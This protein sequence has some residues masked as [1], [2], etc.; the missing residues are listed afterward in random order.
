MARTPAPEA[1]LPRVLVGIP[2]HR[3]V[4]GPFLQS[5]VTLLEECH[6]L[7]LDLRVAYAPG[8][9]IHLARDNLVR[10]FL[11]GSW[12]Y[13]VMVDTDQ[14]FSPEV[15]RRL[16]RWGKPLVA[17]VIVNRLGDPKPVAYAREGTSLTG[18]AVYAALAEEVWAYLSQ[19]RPERLRAPT[20]TLPLGADG[21]PT[22]ADLP[23][24]VRAGLASPLLAVDAVGGGMTC[25]SRAC[26]ERL[27]PT[28]G[29]RYFGWEHG[30]EDLSFC[31]LVLEAGYAG[32]D[33]DWRHSPAEA[34]G[35][36]HGI[37]VDRG[38][39]VGHL[40][41]YAR[42]AVDLGNF[43]RLGRGGADEPA[44]GGL[45][46]VEDVAE[47]LAADGARPSRGPWDMEPLP[48]ELEGALGRQAA[49]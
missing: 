21:P 24:P 1:A 13:L 6:R 35:R 4:E 37:F 29:G 34:E 23:D 46:G 38:C 15:V 31:R 12:D 33:P 19:Y 17:P 9:A 10:F 32:F 28:E 45:G 3:S 5:V 7:T 47:R 2:Y 30:G 8:T 36:E 27:R 41:A 43:L 42:G 20:V 18:D 26:A 11:A 40:T 16:V 14:V 25:L 48:A 44:Q 22:M 39:V 49:T